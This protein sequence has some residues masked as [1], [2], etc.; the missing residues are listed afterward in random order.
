MSGISLSLPQGWP[1]SL[2]FLIAAVIVV[3]LQ[4]IPFTGIILMFALAMFWSVFLIN[5][6]MIGI[7]WEALNG[8]VGKAWLILPALY[9]GGYYLA[10]GW[11]RLAVQRIT[12]ELATF[13]ADKHLPFDPAARDLVFEKGKG[14]MHI[15]L[16]PLLET[17]DL[18]RYFED[19]RVNFI[20]SSEACKLAREE[21]AKT[22]GI[23]ASWLST[24]RGRG[25]RG[26]S[27]KPRP[28][29]GPCTITAPGRPDRPVL[30]ITSDLTS[31]QRQL[32]P[33]QIMDLTLRD[34]TSGE[35]R[36]VRSI[37]ASLL[38]PFPMPVIGYALNS[39]AP[40][41][42]GFAGFMRSRSRPLPAYGAD[43]P[44]PGPLD[45]LA[46]T[47]GLE[48]SADPASRAVGAETVAALT[49]AADKALTDKELAILEAMLADPMVYHRN[50][51][52]YHLPQRPAVV[53]PYAGRIV[54]ALGQLQ[55]SEERVS[56][57]GR[58][59]WRLLA[60][61]PD[62]DLAPHRAKLVEWLD[63]ANARDWTRRTGE[64]Y[65]RLDAAVPAER[66][67]LLQR[68]EANRGDLETR[69]LPGFCR[70][71]SA[72]PA[73]VKHRLLAIWQARAPD[74]AKPRDERGQD[75]VQLY[76]TL[77]RLGLKAQAGQVVQRYFGPTYAAIWSD[78][79][80]DTH[81]ELCRAT[82]NDLT[83]HFRWKRAKGPT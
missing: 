61:L 41:W 55:S 63:P 2:W 70:M 31:E 18:T 25:L 28:A 74:P 51:W 79:K 57:T 59:L 44:A 65:A 58:N 35:T 11:E 83:N 19:E 8:K 39:G 77:A 1:V 9:F 12:N 75:D 71:G 76:F 46:R 26:L 54:A 13:N 10:Y 69:L 52:F 64:I 50:G 15:S 40:S 66:A 68:L 82:L 43:Q 27:A 32:V 42:E 5:A 67:I 60:A 30:R 34:E 72:A 3:V 16:A 17:H 29:G 24:S 21:L 81:E 22:S 53:A 23:Q 36:Q 48:R 14:D 80:A 38:S 56:E 62:A 6:A 49:Q 7:T 33:L 20:G 47:L 37:K 73:E 78:V 4:R 45:I